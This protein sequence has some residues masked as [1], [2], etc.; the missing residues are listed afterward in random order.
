MYLVDYGGETE[1]KTGFYD[2]TKIVI[3]WLALYNIKLNPSFIFP[4]TDGG[5]KCTGVNTGLYVAW[6]L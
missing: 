1:V 3:N 6:K 5:T 4:T 2:V